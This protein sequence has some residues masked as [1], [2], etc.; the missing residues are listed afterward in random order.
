[1]KGGSPVS[2]SFA[3][4]KP[5]LL[6]FVPHP[7]LGLGPS[8][9]SCPAPVH[10]LVLDNW[11]LKTRRLSLTGS[12]NPGRRTSLEMSQLSTLQKPSSLY[13]H[14]Q[15]VQASVPPGQS[16]SALGQLLGQ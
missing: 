5:S 14:N 1:M 4:V 7:H 10:M 3:G 11:E 13:P 2:Q 9:Q 6:I 16:I 12:S 15:E 8:V